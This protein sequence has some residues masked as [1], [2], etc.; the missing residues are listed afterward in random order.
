MYE[1]EYHTATSL[2]DAA[3]RLADEDAKLVAGGMTL[4][5]TLKQRL[6]KP[7]QL[8]DLGKI[9][10]LKGITEE[11]DAV[12][13]GAMTRHVD[14][15]RSEIVRRVIPSLAEL[16]GMIGDPAVRNRGTIGGSISNNDPAADY[17]GAV[18]AL[19]ATVRTSKREIAGDDFFT[20]LFETALEPG[21]IVTAVK[22]PRIQAANYQK[23]RNPASRYAIVGVYVARTGSGVRV[24]VTGAGA[25]VFRVPEME[26]AL[27][28]SFK[29]DAIQDIVIPQDDL[30]S[31]IHASAEYRAHLVNVMA[32]RAVAACA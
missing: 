18:V 8:I 17:P 6:A 32:R 15:S 13:V 7:T 24:A 19:N 14:V 1:F 16:A 9:A 2:D 26:A 31:D 21:E 25:F 5:P 4:I 10:S 3:G 11:G 20:G 28:K 27:A 29:P 22:F 30:N 23:F 12:V